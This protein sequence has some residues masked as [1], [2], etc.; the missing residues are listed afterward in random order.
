MVELANPHVGVNIAHFSNAMKTRYLPGMHQQFSSENLVYRLFET[1]TDIVSGGEVE[2]SLVTQR[3]SGFGAIPVEGR[4]ADAH[5]RGRSTMNFPVRYI[6]GALMVTGPVMSKS[7]DAAGAF[8]E[9]LDTAISDLT[10]DALHDMDRIFLG[11][12]SGRLA[13][14]TDVSQ[15]AVGRFLAREVHDL[16][17]QG[18]TLPHVREGDMVAV[19]D[20]DAVGNPATVTF[21]AEATSGNTVE[22][23]VV[24]EVD[25]QNK[26]FTLRLIDPLTGAAAAGAIDLSTVE[27]G[28]ALIRIVS[29]RDADEVGEPTQLQYSNYHG[30]VVPVGSGQKEPMGLAGIVAATN[31]FYH[32]DAAGNSAATIDPAG[33]AGDPLQNVSVSNGF[34]RANVNDPFA[35]TRAL[36]DI[37][38]QEAHDLMEERGNEMLEFLLCSYGVRRAYKALVGPDRR[39]DK[40][41]DFDLGQRAMDF[42]EAPMVAERYVSPG[43]IY[44]LS[45]S[46]FT[47]AMEDP[48][49]WI[50][51][52]GAVLFRIPRYNKFSANLWW[53]GELCTYRRNTCS[54][55]GSIRE[56]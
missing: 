52:D 40:T 39:F 3:S 4:I 10:E 8:A 26:A 55:L 31:P 48:W 13:I 24:T 56:F 1:N 45:R 44:F 34:W 42:N 7:R 21:C 22:R 46:P 15:A 51:E 27:E 5:Y 19:V 49:H 12:G 11:D 50:E 25:E 9:A 53:A 17:N 16:A 30:G 41:L 2:L 23:F 36:D 28:D 32:Y 6:S 54:Y 18:R 29:Q 20:A 35:G 33:Y 14:I 38:M 47:I 37:L 43:R